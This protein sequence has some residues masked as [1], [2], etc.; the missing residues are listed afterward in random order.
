MRFRSMIFAS[1][2]LCGA[3]CWSQSSASAGAASTQAINAQNENN[4]CRIYFTKAKS[5]QE[6]Q[7]E[8]GRK[9]HIQFHRAQKDTWTWNTWTRET[10]DD[11]GSY[12]TSTCGHAWK[13]FDEWE[14]R[15]GKADAADAL[16]NMGPY[17]G[18]ST[19]GFYLYRADMSLA[20]ANQPPAPMAAVTIYTLHPGAAPDFIAA[21]KKV[22]DALSKQPDWPKTSGWYQ[23]VNG[24]QG[25]TFVLV[26]ARQNWAG[27]EPLAKSVPDVLNEVY[28]PE[29]AGQIL[30]TM[31]DSTK[32]LS[33]ETALY[34]PELSYVPAK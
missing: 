32:H 2:L 3:L 14:A 22:N 29:T 13:D 26:S 34:H 11:T 21:V 5:G 27:F 33:T 16:A 12:V 28:G 31:R 20:P 4:L 10:G 23:L 1:G 24:G 6:Q 9:K 17:L 25:P 30:K 15:M 8:A 19:D 18:G 7:L